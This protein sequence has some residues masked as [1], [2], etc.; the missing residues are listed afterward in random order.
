MP[1][2]VIEIFDTNWEIIVPHVTLLTA[3]E[4]SCPPST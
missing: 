4:K 3:S 2:A 1:W